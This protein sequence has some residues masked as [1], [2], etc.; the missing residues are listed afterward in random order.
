MH[1]GHTGSKQPSI[2]GSTAS[3]DG[4]GS[5]ERTLLCLLFEVAM[6][7]AEG[8]QQK[9][10]GAV[11]LSSIE[12]YVLTCG[13][14][15]TNIIGNM[16]WSTRMHHNVSIDGMIAA[17]FQDSPNVACWKYFSTATAYSTMCSKADALRSPTSTPKA[18]QE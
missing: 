16:I 7:D 9:L 10:A 17:A 15:I 14:T 12:G 6:V 5:H 13:Q 2:R 4:G 3:S 1:H 18:W 11:T 8:L